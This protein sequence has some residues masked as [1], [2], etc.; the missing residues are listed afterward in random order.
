MKNTHNTQ[1]NNSLIQLSN[2]K[3]VPPEILELVR[4]VVED[5]IPNLSHD[6]LYTLRGIF[7]EEEWSYFDL[8]NK[9]DAG[10]CM[11]HLVAKGALP[12]ISVNTC[13]HQSPKKYRLK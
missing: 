12:M 7:G 5:R 6:K 8:M 11:V 10:Y 9:I 2:G 4:L 13:R 1:S 3:S